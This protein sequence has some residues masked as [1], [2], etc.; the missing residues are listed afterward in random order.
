MRL[1]GGGQELRHLGLERA[2]LDELVEGELRFRELADRDE[3]PVDADRADG[4]V[5]TRAVEEA[6]VAQGVRF[7]DAATDRRDD[8]LDDAHQMRLVLEERRHG[9]EHAAALDEDVLVTVDEDVG[10]G[11]VLEERLERS[12]AR[13]LV[14]HLGDEE[15]ELLGVEGQALGHDPVGDDAV[16]LAPK[17]LPRQLLERREVELLDETAVEANLRVEQL[18]VGRGRR[19]GGGGRHGLRRLGNGHDRRRRRGLARPSR[20]AGGEGRRRSRL[21]WNA[22]HPG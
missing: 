5:E 2:D 22:G 1:D 8:L 13:H 12:Q 19:R 16:D 10:D 20:R 14:H 18:L 6:R 21:R 17:L 4:A 11:R 7:V 3:R 9:L 15:V